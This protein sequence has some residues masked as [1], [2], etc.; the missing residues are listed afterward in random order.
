MNVHG[1]EDPA[2]LSLRKDIATFPVDATVQI[3]APGRYGAVRKSPS[4][5]ACGVHDYPCTHPGVDIPVSTGGTAVKAP[6]DGWILYSGP[7][8]APPWVG[9]R[10]GVVLIAHH[11]SGDSFWRR[12][13]KGL[14][15]PLIK[16][17]DFPENPLA[18]RYSLLAHVH[19]LRLMAMPSDVVNEGSSAFRKLDD[20][21]L[22]MTDQSDVYKEGFSHIDITNI[23]KGPTGANPR[24]VH[25]GD[26]VAVT[27]GPVGHVHWEIRTRP[28]GGTGYTIDPFDFMRLQYGKTPDLVKQLE[29]GTWQKLKTAAGGGGGGDA[30]LL[31]GLLWALSDKSR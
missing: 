2:Q 4:D 20:G 10:P 31:L 21:T 18:A 9:Y 3:P 28:L 22:I 13:L 26:T 30:L 24:Y 1:A 25:T 14:T 16:A 27:D 8:D 6:H 23:G 7:A 29:T 19:P 15:Q 17:F 11:D 5:G 12:F